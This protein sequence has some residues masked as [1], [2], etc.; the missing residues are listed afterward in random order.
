M[1][2]L[3]S[4]P[5]RAQ[6]RNSISSSA[7]GGNFGAGPKPACTGSNARATFST[8]PASSSAV[9]VAA[10]PPDA[11]AAAATSR[12]MSAPDASTSSRRVRHALVT[13]SSNWRNDPIPAR[14][15]GGK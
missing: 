6:C 13:A 3:A 7:D 5:V 14:G 2:R 10:G 11:R 8:A 4:S 9:S 12:A 15:V 1:R